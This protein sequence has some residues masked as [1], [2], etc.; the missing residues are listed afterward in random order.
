[1]KRQGARWLAVGVCVW[2]ET[3]EGEENGGGN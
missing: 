2:E 1:M 3:E